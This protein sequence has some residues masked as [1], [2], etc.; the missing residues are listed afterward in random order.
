MPTPQPTSRMEL[1]V[2]DAVC[3]ARADGQIVVIP[4]AIEDWEDVRMRSRIVERN[5]VS[6]RAQS[7]LLDLP[8]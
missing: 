8:V 6:R 3:H 2:T 1:G 4:L 7:L 5:L